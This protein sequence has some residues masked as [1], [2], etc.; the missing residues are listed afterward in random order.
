MFDRDIEEARLVFTFVNFLGFL[1]IKE[2]KESKEIA[3]ARYLAAVN[4]KSGAW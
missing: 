1:G 4:F 3:L 2:A